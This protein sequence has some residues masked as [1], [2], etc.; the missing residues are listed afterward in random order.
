MTELQNRVRKGEVVAIE[1]R[2]SSTTMHGPTTSYT[3]YVLATVAKANL[4]GKAIRVTMAGQTHSLEVA[5]LGAVFV[6][7]TY[8]TEAQILAGLTKY[9]GIEYETKED[10]KAAILAAPLATARVA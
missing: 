3:R 9:P 4:Q 5:R 10:L 1:V 8:K 6:L 2:H 7:K